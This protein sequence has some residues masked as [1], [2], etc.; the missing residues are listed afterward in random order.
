MKLEA[1]RR[2]GGRLEWNQAL[3]E[4]ENVKDRFV[5]STIMI[6]LDRSIDATRSC[7]QGQWGES[8]C[9]SGIIKDR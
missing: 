5:E 3:G 1:G 2:V 4:R 6:S 7:M 8:I 9:Q